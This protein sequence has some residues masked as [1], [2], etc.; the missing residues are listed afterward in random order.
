[1]LVVWGL[2][3]FREPQKQ[4]RNQTSAAI[5]DNVAVAHIIFGPSK[6]L[7]KGV[8]APILWGG[9]PFP[10]GGV[11]AEYEMGWQQGPGY[12]HCGMHPLSGISHLTSKSHNYLQ[13]PLTRTYTLKKVVYNLH[14]FF[15]AQTLSVNLGTPKH[16]S[17]VLN[18][19]VGTSRT[20]QRSVWVP[21]NLE[22][23]IF[24]RSLLLTL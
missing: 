9:F 19:G 12:F 10:Q 1:M 2:G 18:G 24:T 14:G 5:L 6:F 20:T 21:S 13:I 22:R 8:I 23:A 15:L 7:R 11:C 17:G 16:R 3:S 4:I